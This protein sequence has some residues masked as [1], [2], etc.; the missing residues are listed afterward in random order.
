MDFL[1][2]PAMAQAAE[3]PAGSIFG[4]LLF[5]ILLI[6]IFYFL[7]I[8]PQQKR[9]K[10][11]REMVE[12]VTAGTEVVTG[13]GVLGKVTAVGEQYFAVEVAEGTTIQ[14]QK[15]AIGAVMPKGTIKAARG[16]KGAGGSGKGKASGRISED[17]DGADDSASHRE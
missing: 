11:H 12:A 17:A 6:V 3:A 10:E 13:G 8:R 2:S 14:V 15:H 9:Q 16:G 4:S 7:I 1:I 5:P